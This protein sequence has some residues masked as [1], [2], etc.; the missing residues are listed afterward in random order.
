L[1]SR[2][3]QKVGEVLIF[4]AVIMCIVILDLTMKTV[5]TAVC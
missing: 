4:I 1:L 2:N 3:V 5:A